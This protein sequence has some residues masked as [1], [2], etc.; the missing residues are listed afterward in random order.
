ML[1]SK[2]YIFNIKRFSLAIVDEASQI[3]EP[4]IIGILSA[5]YNENIDGQTL[6][7]NCI[8]KFILVGDYK[9]LPA[10][11]Q[12]SERDSSVSDPLLK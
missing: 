4:N 10:V 11:V 5:H 3:L 2:P 12:Q 9:Q 8:R 6:L 7:R 1:V